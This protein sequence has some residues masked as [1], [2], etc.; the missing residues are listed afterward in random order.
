MPFSRLIV[1]VCIAAPLGYVAGLALTQSPVVVHAEPRRISAHELIAEYIDSRNTGSSDAFLAFEERHRSARA[2]AS[3]AMDDRIA[4][5]VSLQ[6]EWGQMTLREITRVTPAA[7]T[8]LIQTER[9]GLHEFTFEFDPQEQ[10]K[11]HVIRISS[12][13]GLQPVTAEAKRSAIEAIADALAESYVFPELGNRMAEMLRTNLNSGAYADIATQRDLAE[14]ITEELR[15]ICADKHLGVLAVPPMPQAGAAP[16]MRPPTNAAF[17]KVEILDGNIGYIRFDGFVE[18]EDAQRIAAAAMNF[19]AN[20]NAVIFDLRHNG[21][22]SP[23]MV[24]FI[25]SYLLDE[26]THLNS[27]YDRDG[28]RTSEHWTHEAVPGKRLAA[29]VPVYILTSAHTFSGAEEFA[30]NLKAL[31]RATIVGEVTGGGAHPVRGLRLEGG[32]MVRIPYL[33]ANNPITGENWEGVGVEPHIIVPA[34]EALERALQ[35]I[36]GDPPHTML[37]N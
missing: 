31:Q 5:A 1:V 4:Q 33:R 35:D 17:R 7:A 20:S 2:L 29:H 10:G 24:A 27:F 19:V 21:G 16:Q 23:A 14:R 8:A 13:A 32:F 34:A 3:R 15:A 18:S 25:T 6:K 36:A 30:Y 12:A 26:P 28:N 37:V 9:A 11:L 22:G